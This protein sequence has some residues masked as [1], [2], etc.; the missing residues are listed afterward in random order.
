M[1]ILPPEICL[2]PVYFGNALK[3]RHQLPPPVTGPV[4][5]GIQTYWPIWHYYSLKINTLNDAVQKKNDLEAQN[6]KSLLLG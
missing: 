5:T 4:E 1:Q 2:Y 6:N 3:E